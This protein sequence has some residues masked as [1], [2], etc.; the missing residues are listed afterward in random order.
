MLRIFSVAALA[1][2]V[3]T[4]AWAGDVKIDGSTSVANSIVLPHQA[5]IEKAAGVKIIVTPKPSGDGVADVFAGKA[6][7]AMISSDLNEIVMKMNEAANANKVDKS[8]LYSFNL[9]TAKVEFIVNEKN[10]V[11][12]L[13]GDQIKAMYLG[14]LTNWKDV[15]GSAGTILLV[16]EFKNGAMRTILERDLLGGKAM[17]DLVLEGKTLQVGK[18]VAIS[19]LSIGFISSTMPEDLRAGTASVATDVELVQHLNLVTQ[20]EPSGDVKR[21]VE[22]IEKF[23]I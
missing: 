7:I 10:P 18:N 14:T 6:D 11:R 8:S 2:L 15:G 4:S 20:G 23:H 9:G 13:T 12:K 1:V 17:S 22:A 5:E 19:P 21:V 3:S 16:T